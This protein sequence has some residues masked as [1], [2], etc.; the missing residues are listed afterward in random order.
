MGDQQ[1]DRGDEFGFD[2]IRKDGRLENVRERT[3]N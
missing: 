1:V 3:I 2:P